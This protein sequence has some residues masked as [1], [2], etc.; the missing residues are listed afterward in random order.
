MRENMRATISWAG[1]I[2][3]LLGF[4]IALTGVGF[5]NKEVSIIGFSWIIVGAVGLW[6]RPRL[7]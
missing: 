4:M 2:V 7:Y 6:I 5:G 3:M 1:A